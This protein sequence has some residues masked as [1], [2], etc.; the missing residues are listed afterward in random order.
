VKLPNF[1]VAVAALTLV[2]SPALSQP[3]QLGICEPHQRNTPTKTCVV[4]GDTLWLQGEKIRL[5]GFDTPEV[6]EP[7]CSSE[8]KLA[9]Q[10]T[11]RLTA[12]LNGSDWKLN[13]S[14]KKDRNGRTL[15]TITIRSKDVGDTL[16]AEGLAHDWN[17]RRLSWCD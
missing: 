3:V 2:A 11:R 5:E 15:A 4:D 1:V 7:K 16:I 14:G 10:A 9:N 17:G 13:R 6:S 12:L 8:K